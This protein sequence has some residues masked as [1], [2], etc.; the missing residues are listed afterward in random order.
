V[1][2][3]D[4]ALLAGA[5]ATIASFFARRWHR[6]GRRD[7]LPV[8][9]GALMIVGSVLVGAWKL[10]VR[11]GPAGEPASV[12]VVSPEP[13]ATGDGNGFAVG[14]AISVRGCGERVH[15]TVVANGTA[16]YWQRR[17]HGFPSRVPVRIA[18]PGTDLRGLA[19]GVTDNATAVGLPTRAV[20][21]TR[22]FFR[23][24]PPRETAGITAVSGTV[25]YWSKHLNSIVA[26]FDADWLEPRGIGTCYLRLPALTGGLSVLAA[27]TA[28]GR[29]SARPKTRRPVIRSV[30][31][32]L[33]AVYEPALETT[34]A[35][36]TV[37]VEDG[38]VDDAASRPGPDQTFEGNPVW[39][40]ETSPPVARELRDRPRGPVADIV[41]GSST[42]GGAY[43]E[44]YI[45][46]TRGT[47]CDG[48]AVI[49]ERSAGTKR[50][51]LLLA[52]GATFSLGA[53]IAAETA[54]RPADAPRRA[55]RRRRP[56]RRRHK[57]RE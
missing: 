50:D 54:L 57:R 13:G 24:D 32:G 19:V 31:T 41:S 2:G 44:A 37:T 30:R 51:L 55:A 5:F 38:D 9:W 52:L 20:R 22:T 16:D 29:V 8:L 49:V 3:V 28:R 40:C 25:F 14:M 10:P 36:T 18:L 34:L 15:V 48:T 1:S 53:A 11:Q 4:V 42:A 17:A 7:R 47:E 23:P 27:Q 39:A 46:D 6:S 45:K 26:T 12:G 33:A 43:S 56:R 35:S 21:E